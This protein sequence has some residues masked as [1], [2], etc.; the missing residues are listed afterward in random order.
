MI[1][2]L[3]L[4]LAVVPMWAFAK[5]A[6]MLWA[7]GF[8][9][10]FMVQGAWG[11]IPA[12]NTDLT[13]DSVRGF[14]PGFAYQRGVLIA[15]TAPFIHSTLAEKHHMSYASVMAGTALVVFAV[16]ATVVG[17]GPEKSGRKFGVVEA[18]AG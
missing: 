1:I 15:G 7:G 17:L 9:I 4:G 2:A 18:A 3:V 13:P 14:K 5:T 11:V 12:H 8:L 6:T 10:Q 16:T